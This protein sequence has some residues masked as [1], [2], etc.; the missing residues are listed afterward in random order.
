[1]RLDIVRGQR[2]PLVKVQPQLQLTAQDWRSSVKKL[3]FGTM[4]GAYQCLLLKPSYS[5]ISQ[6][7]WENST[8]V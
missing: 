8:M 5:R 1:M 7:F 4:K 2:R 3:R 6:C